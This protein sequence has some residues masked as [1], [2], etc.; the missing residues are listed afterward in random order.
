MKKF[1]IHTVET[2]PDAAIPA[3]NVTKAKF[4]M[5][6]NLFALMAES[7]AMLEGYIGLS[8][9]FFE[10]T[11]LTDTERQLVLMT[12]SR[13]NGCKYCMTGHTVEATSQ[14]VSTDVVEAL[15]AGSELSDPRLE[16]LRRFTKLVVQTRGTPEPSDVQAL[17]DAGFTRQTVL[18]VVMGVGLKT[19]SNFTN[20]IVKT[21]LDDATA[22]RSWPD[23][24]GT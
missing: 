5:I 3:L 2:A 23:A 10:N 4:G 16:A 19:L 20:H 22:H 13:L 12:V 6:P 15:R 11:A 7:P 18:E 24:Q 14:K 21:P 1:Q 17:I 8:K 9:L